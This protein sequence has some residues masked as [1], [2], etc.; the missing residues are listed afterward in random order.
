MGAVD[1]YPT[2][3]PEEPQ[4]QPAATWPTT[5]PAI[6]TSSSAPAVTWTWNQSASLLSAANTSVAVPS[7]VTF[8]FT[9]GTAGG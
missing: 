7:V 4:P 5:W 2:P 1:T 6:I 8:S 3:D 9:A